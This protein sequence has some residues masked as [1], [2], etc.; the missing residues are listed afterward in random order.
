MNGEIK[1]TTMNGVLGRMRNEAAVACI[2]QFLE[3]LRKT[4][5]SL[6]QDSQSQGRYSNPELPNMKQ[7]C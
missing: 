6:K 4:T 1:R 3:D 5:K 2:G 7:E